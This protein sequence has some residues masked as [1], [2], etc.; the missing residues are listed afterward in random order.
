MYN[1][2][3]YS[4]QYIQSHEE[5]A[6]PCFEDRDGRFPKAMM[7]E[8]LDLHLGKYMEYIGIMFSKIRC[9]A[10]KCGAAVYF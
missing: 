8:G 1:R 2:F 7:I 10:C 3:M 5:P 4:S 6:H 9:N